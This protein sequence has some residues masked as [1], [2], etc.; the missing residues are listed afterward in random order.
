MENG[1][2]MF[3]NKVIIF[4]NRISTILDIKNWSIV[5]MCTLSVFIVVALIANRNKILNWI[6]RI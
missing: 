6:K 3:E 2:A 1:G 4:I 5:A